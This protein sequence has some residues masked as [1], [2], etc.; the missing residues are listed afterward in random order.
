MIATP[1]FVHVI[2]DDDAVRESFALLLES[3]GFQTRSFASARAFL[4]AVVK[5]DLAATAFGCVLSDI[6]MPDM[7]GLE[8]LAAM[9]KLDVKLPIVLVTAYAD[10]ALA[11]QAMK[12]GAADFIEKPCDEDE[13]IAA[14]RNALA[15]SSDANAQE[16][17]K[18]AYLK[19]LESLTE[20][21]NDV[22]AGLLEGKLNKTIAYD[23]GVSVR[24]V[25]THRAAIMSK[26]NAGSLSELVRLSLLAGWK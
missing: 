25:E 26:T 23:L 1:G 7:S 17:E 24:T 15:D 6:R 21:E 10:V 8:L 3:D 22:L 20:R 9:K 2:D 14:V 11:V 16:A 4:A 19:R 13:L 5:E 18:Q 12:M